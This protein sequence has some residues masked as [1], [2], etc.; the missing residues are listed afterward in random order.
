MTFSSEINIHNNIINKTFLFTFFSYF[1]FSTLLSLFRHIIILLSFLF[2]SLPYISSTLPF[3]SFYFLFTH[4][5][6][7]YSF[8]L[9]NS[10]LILSH[11]HSIFSFLIYIAFFICVQFALELW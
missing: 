5:F 10:T 2:P 8:F 1:S 6:Y 3:N 4:H 11:I 9:W 7:K